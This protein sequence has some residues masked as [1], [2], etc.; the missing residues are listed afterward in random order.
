MGIFVLDFPLAYLISKLLYGWTWIQSM[1]D[2]Q[3][4]VAALFHTNVHGATPRPLLIFSRH[5]QLISDI[6]LVMSHA[7]LNLK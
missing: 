2:L 4:Y 7:Y 1:S 3:N 6:L 5:F